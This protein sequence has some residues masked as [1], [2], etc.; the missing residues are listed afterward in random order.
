MALLVA[1]FVGAMDQT[2][3]AAVLPAFV[4]DLSIPFDKLDEA[5]WAVTLYLAAYAAIVPTGGRLIDSG[6]RSA[7]LLG[8]LVVFALG[9]VVCGV[10][11]SLG[12]LV[13]GR[14]V[15][16]L[17]AGVLLP[18]ALASA[19]AG[20]PDRRLFRIGLVLAVAE[21]GAVCGPLYGAAA[22]AWLD[23][24]W[25]FWL[26]VPLAAAVA[27][28][29]LRRGVPH[30]ARPSPYALFAPAGVG[31]ALGLI[32]AGVSRDAARS[33]VWVGPACVVCAAALLV[34]FVAR[35]DVMRSR[36]FGI[37]L[38]AHVLLGVA[39]MVPLVLIPVWA[40]TLLALD[41][42]GSAQVLLR[43]TLAIP[44]GAL[45]GAAAARLLGTRPV[46]FLGFGLVAVGL[47]FMSHWPSTITV[48]EMTPA[49]LLAGL[50]FGCL[51]AP[52]TELVFT[53]SDAQ[54]V[55]SAVG[56]A[57]A[58]RVVG[59]AVGLS[60]LTR[61]GLDQLV[62]R[63]AEIPEPNLF[64]AGALAEYARAAANVAAEIL[65]TLFQVGAGCAA[66]AG[67]GILALREQSNRRRSENFVLQDGGGL[68]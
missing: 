22:L 17:G 9:S 54:R 18:V 1:V 5:G 4:R 42:A 8:G 64:T 25:V 67:V 46:A 13:V 34:P 60:L 31:L 33:G 23:W 39:L 58:A 20:Q 40:N 38:G 14:V 37:V 3:V 51:L 68:Q 30:P 45:I 15:Q 56:L 2:V 57:T 65:G 48:M 6:A 53:V 10:A 12:V 35:N 16:A 59:M 7:A 61:W 50:G 24:R 52:L 55:G 21:A 28:L 11:G 41:A 32:V 66:L 49:L 27:V 47:Q 26:N 63:L 44:P 19:G 29:Y 43:M 36:S 62:A